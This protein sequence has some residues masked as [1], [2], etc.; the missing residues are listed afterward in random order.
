MTALRRGWGSVRVSTD[1]QLESTLGVRAYLE[2]I[3]GYGAARGIDFGDVVPVTIGQHRFESRERIIIESASAFRVPFFKRE[4]TRRILSAIEPEQHLVVAK[5]ER[6]FRNSE[7]GLM[8]LRRMRDEFLI[9][10]HFV[11]LGGLHYDGSTPAGF[12]VMY[13]LYL[14]LAEI[15]SRRTSDR[16]KSAHRTAR[17][18]G[19][20]ATYNP[21][22]GFRW[23][24]KGKSRMMVPDLEQLS[25]LRT[26]AGCLAQDM[27]LEAIYRELRRRGVQAVG[28][29]ALDQK[30][31][32]VEIGEATIRRWMAFARM[33]RA[34]EAETGL[35][36]EDGKPWIDAYN[37]RRSEQEAGRQQRSRARRAKGARSRLRSEFPAA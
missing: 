32:G 8:S 33:M 18:G 2:T 25:L 19:R 36:P 20:P 30:R 37:L 31:W 26:I 5:V 12:G 7:D 1:E 27:G 10:P 9:Y 14:A 17:L 13:S 3:I 28:R 11:D 23:E 21:L 16:V 15:E 29:S 24:G 4:G 35:K 34:I 22:T 6:A